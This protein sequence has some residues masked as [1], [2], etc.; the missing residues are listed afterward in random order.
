M[1]K[2]NLQSTEAVKKLKEL[3]EKARVC[4]FCTEL[5]D[6]PLKGRPMSIQET[7]AEGNLWFLSSDDSNKNFE[8]REDNRVQLFFS[9]NS[10]YE[11]LSVYGEATIYKDRST[12][13]DKWSEM[14][15][16]WFDGK[17]DPKVAV[18]RVA[19]KDS[20]YWDTKAGKLVTLLSFATAVISGSKTD[21]DDGVEG[22]LT[23]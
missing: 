21:N 7:D 22:N 8:I 6:L 11:Y 13:E 5:T 3:S 17:D 9:N 19:P 20:Y 18:I 16:A 12:I 1:S 14:A 23:V 2:E 10:D 15:N 4:M